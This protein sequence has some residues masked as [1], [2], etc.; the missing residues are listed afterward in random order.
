MVRVLAYLSPLVVGLGVAAA[1]A[2]TEGAP[3][4]RRLFAAG[5][6]PAVLLVLLLPAV[7]TESLAAWL[8]IAALLVSFAA[9]V[10][11][12]ML[13][14]EPLRLRPEIAQV[15]AGVAVVA[16]VGS[17]FWAGPLIREAADV[18]PGGKATYRRISMTLAV[19]P[20]MV[21]G[22]SVFGHDPLHTTELYAMGLH[23]YMFDKPGWSSTSAGYAVAGLL[24]AALSRGLLGLR[25]RGPP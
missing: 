12:L 17:V 9:F 24:L 16:L 20:Y 7:A 25:K 22:Y 15:A 18:D 14:G 1:L 13:L 8:K 3:R 4:R 21:L 11:G 23:D 6:V 2:L 10:A 19:S 5:G